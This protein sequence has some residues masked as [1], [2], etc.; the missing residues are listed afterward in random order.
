[1]GEDQ[2]RECGAPTDRCAEPRGDIGLTKDAESKPI[3][4]VEEG[5]EVTNKLPLLRKNLN[6]V[7]DAGEEGER[8]DEEVLKRGHMVPFLCVEGGNES[9]CAQNQTGHESK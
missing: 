7:K 1:M 4:Q 9:E 6:G 8:V 5:I 2:E 3:D